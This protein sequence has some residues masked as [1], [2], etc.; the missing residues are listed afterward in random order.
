MPPR[1]RNARHAVT[2]ALNRLLGNPPRLVIPWSR[3]ALVTPAPGFR[4]PRSAGFAVSSRRALPRVTIPFRPSVS[5][6]Q[7]LEKSLRERKTGQG[8]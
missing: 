7:S 4:K 6:W 2:P 5:R 1:E 3:L 8:V